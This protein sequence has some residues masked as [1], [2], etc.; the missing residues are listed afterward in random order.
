M[1]AHVKGTSVIAMTRFL[2]ESFGEQGI[3]KIAERLGTEDRERLKM[4]ILPS[5]WLP[6]SFMLAVMRAARSE[7]GNMMP[8]LYVRMGRA[9]ADYSLSTVY[10]MIFKVSSTQW[11]ISRAAAVYANYYDTGKM[12]VVEN[13]TGFAM[14]EL[15]GAEEP[16]PELCDRLVGW[17]ERVLEHCGAHW[18]KVDHSKCRCRGD[19][20][21]AFK[22]SW[23]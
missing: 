16:A 17:C 5:A 6:I 15:N 1:T 14:L 12:S 19:A 8:D 21:C 10:S 11:I 4:P 23:S 2:K 22:A 7:F 13:G 18:V 9:S 3:D 20:V